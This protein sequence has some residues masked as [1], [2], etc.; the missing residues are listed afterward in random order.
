MSALNATHI[1][2]NRGVDFERA[3]DRLNERAGKAFRVYLEAKRSKDATEASINAARE[4]YDVANS[5]FR[6]L[7]SN[8]AEAIARV[9][10]EVHA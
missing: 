4:A 3:R 7:R 10:S 8:D 1:E 2:I 6:A 5:E 9:L